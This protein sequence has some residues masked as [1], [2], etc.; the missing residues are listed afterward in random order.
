[1]K[2]V[3]T[4]EVLSRL[5][6]LL[7]EALDLDPAAREAWLATLDGEALALAPTLR[8]LLARRATK[9]TADLLERGPA[10]TLPASAGPDATAFKPG[11]TVGPYRL[12]RSLGHGG[13]GEV[14]QAE[15][16]DGTL[17]RKV[18][19]KLPHV[20]WAPGLAERFA[21]EREILSSLEHPNIARLYDAGLD[22]HG[23]PYMA[24]EYVEGLPIDEYCKQHALPVE[25]R[26]RLLL[27]VADAVAFAHSRLVVHRDLKPGNILVTDDGQVRLLDFGIAKLMEGEATQET[28]LTKVG[29]RAL[30]LDYASPEQI[31]GQPIGTS[32]DVY[33]LAVVAF[34]L[35]AGA[36]PY[37]LKRGSAAELE[38][39][40][41]GQ[42]LSLASSL[43]QEPAAAK[44]LRGDLD[45]ILN[46]ALKKSV[47]ERY[48]TVDALAQDWRRH[49]D[50]ERVRARPDTLGYRAV[51]FV[52]RQRIPLTV[53]SLAVVAFVLALGFGA[54]AV[55]ILALLVGLGAA[56]WQ[57]RKA[58]ELARLAHHQEERALA[59]QDFLLGL[60]RANADSQ[61]DPVSARETT[62][63][64]LL[65]VGA[66]RVREQ[67]KTSPAAQDAVL[68]TLA[69]MYVDVGLDQEAADLR[70]ERVVV[71]ERLYGPNDPRLAAA[72]LDHATSLSSTSDAARAPA[73][74]L[75]A[76]RIAEQA[77]GDQTELRIRILF[78]QAQ[79]YR[80]ANVSAALDFV[81]EAHGLI[82][83]TG[84]ASADLRR[85]LYLEGLTL[86]FLGECATALKTLQQAHALSLASPGPYAQWQIP[87]FT[88]ISSQ[89]ICLGDFAL[90][91]SSLLEALEMSRR[92][93][94][95]DHIDTNH[96]LTRL[97]RVYHD[98]SRAAEAQAL[99]ERMTGLLGQ[100][101]VQ[102]NV[103]LYTTLLRSSA[104]RALDVGRIDEATSR[105]AELIQRVRGFAGS[106][107]VL[108]TALQQFARALA[109]QG[110]MDEAMRFLNE[111]VA[112]MCASL[113]PRARPAAIAS[114]QIDQAA[115]QLWTGNTVTA[116]KGLDAVLVGLKASPAEARP[117]VPQ[118]ERW[119]AA[120]LRQV[121]RAGEAVVAAQS[122]LDALDATFRPIDLP[123][124]RAD[125]LFEQ[126]LAFHEM[127]QLS[128]A[129]ENLSR[130]MV[131]RGANDDK[132]GAWQ[133]RVEIALAETSLALGDRPM[134]DRLAQTAHQRLVVHPVL[135]PF[136]T[137]PARHIA[138]RLA[139][140]PFS[141]Q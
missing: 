124:L 129:R 12:L 63:R 24:L 102:E 118:I 20:T 104:M 72:L 9:E 52:R 71:R 139:A 92:V 132:A 56:L 77:P 122:G 58:R 111:S 123:R 81:R 8:K 60:F 74:L 32:S 66:A 133:A 88:A 13:M 134:A 38:D 30:T 75:R 94:G 117:L 99:D 1:M 90:A 113:G 36:R 69:D 17:K 115:L 21:R 59:V 48:P 27:Q 95:P 50:G 62:A 98:T 140:F 15:R 135:A 119:R 31:R 93:N 86:G 2:V 3:M 110:R 105:S 64:Q 141:P 11:D 67:L 114:M 68:E 70:A 26:L 61:P 128:L 39:A 35:L 57:A 106:S 47:T 10:F 137:E 4:P 25:G 138:A 83:R 19:L 107:V 91:E 46:K 53:G 125:L 87:E 6:T 84:V 126:G 108:A 80:Y 127:G 40:I 76:R 18:A 28:A 96:V 54:T 7:D 34:E 65:D 22:P 42:E 55:V 79:A 78:G 33:S 82:D 112:M 103:N 41:T 29:G 16:A 14:W 131:L 73:L 5:S 45:A 121:G 49:L 101:M 44:A 130:A 89:A 136:F 85:A 23:R 100:R 37:K 120:S 43:A 51:R 97:M 116:Q 109:A